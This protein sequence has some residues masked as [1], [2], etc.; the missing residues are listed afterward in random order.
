MGLQAEPPLWMLQAIVRG[1]LGV[2]LALRAVH[3]LQKE[4]LKIQM[5]KALWLRAFL[6]IDKFEFLP[7]C[8]DQRRASLGT[9][10]NPID[11]RWWLLCAVGFNSNLKALL[12]Q[13]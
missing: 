9:H 2:A 6:G 8:Q 3:R 10:T 13:C 7:V 11:A 12:V 1:K 5:L 4:M